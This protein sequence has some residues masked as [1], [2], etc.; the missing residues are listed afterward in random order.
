[1]N[2]DCLENLYCTECG[3]T[4]VIDKN[5]NHIAPTNDDEDCEE[6]AAAF[7]S[8]STFKEERQTFLSVSSIEMEKLM[9]E[10]DATKVNDENNFMVS[11]WPPSGLLNN[12]KY[13]IKMIVSTN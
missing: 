4:M 8:T 3:S 6:G 12:I 10:P 7:G 1:M 9:N 2:A 11:S 13:V 5:E